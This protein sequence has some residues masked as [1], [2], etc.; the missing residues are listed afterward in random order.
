MA[1]IGFELRKMFSDENTTFENIKAVGYSTIVSVGPWI[2]TTIVLN[3]FHIIGKIYIPN[4]EEKQILMAAIVYSF[5]FSQVFNSPWQY[6]ITRYI[7][8]CIYSK[9][10]N[11]IK[12]AFTGITK[13]IFLISFLAGSIFMRNSDVPKY[14]SYTAILLFSILSVSWMAMNFVSILKSYSF[15]IKAY[16]MG[17][18]VSL[19]LGYLFMKYPFIKEFKEYPSY[20]ILLAYTLGALITFTSI[21]LQLMSS[22]KGESSSEFK[23][24]RY[25]KGYSILMVSGVL[26]ITGTWSHVFINWIFGKSF[27]IGGVFIVS[28]DYEFAIFFSFLI[29]IPTLIYF[30]IFMETKFFPVYKKYYY[31]INY[32]GK[33]EQSE[34]MREKMIKI[35]KGEIFYIMELQ[36]L[37]SLSFIL[38]SKNLFE[39]FRINLSILDMFRILV[40]GA[41]S[42]VFV[43]VL[44]TIL[45][46]FDAKKEVLIVSIVYFTSNTILSGY[47]IK[48]GNNYNGLGFFLGSFISLL[49]AD[50]LLN[51]V[52]ENLN[53]LTFYNQNFVKIVGNKKTEILE[54]FFNKKGY[55]ILVLLSLLFLT[56]CS[57]YNE[58]GFNV[59]TGRNWHTMGKYD[60][61]GYDYK[62]YNRDGVDKK[63]FTEEGWNRYTQSSYDY[64]GFDVDGIHEETDTLYNERGFNREKIHIITKKEHDE[65]KFNFEGIH[66]ETKT[67]YNSEGWTMYGLNEKTKNEY[68]IHGYNVLGINKKGFTEKGWN[69]FTKSSYDYYGFDV[70]GIHKE[71][72]TLYN[73]RGFNQEK[74][75]VITKKEYDEK[76][77]NF[78]GIH[79]KT[80]TKYNNKGWTW[81]GLNKQTN[82]YY[83]V[84]GYNEDGYN[85]DGYNRNNY[86]IK[87]NKKIDY[88]NYSSLDVNDQN[89]LYDKN[90]RFVDE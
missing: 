77:F 58:K 80:R 73:E 74:I 11:E 13:L 41:Y 2:L 27:K 69:S 50:N 85:R 90:G 47:F 79:I 45:L 53:Y 57:S 72:N 32:N 24:L 9:N 8:D 60:S 63:G 82:A 35:L 37:I 78:E 7:S 55:M 56:G 89:E 46:Y 16:V 31:Y 5:I 64:Y 71:T 84:K 70:K 42:S 75:H 68:D 52:L 62:G 83:D 15:V 61:L 66:I 10:Q 86:D 38:I 29:I 67:E 59:S 49:V 4:P 65:K 18:T 54:K 44:L 1:G 39:Y 23:F 34:K 87:G 43:T 14:F 19:I 76:D 30:T 36:L 12:G 26:F 28:P 17:N 88:S 25:L 21:S 22:F 51:K 48:F 33:L 3:I 6:I 81:Y 40:F 20:G